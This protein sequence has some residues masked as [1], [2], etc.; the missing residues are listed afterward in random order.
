MMR[1]IT[2]RAFCPVA[3]VAFCGQAGTGKSQEEP[4]QVS[5]FDSSVAASSS[6]R[7]YSS[8]MLDIRAETFFPRQCGLL[9]A[10]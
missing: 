10:G 3:D 1:P 4:V 5:E 2:L 7:E 8:K 6:L 9:A